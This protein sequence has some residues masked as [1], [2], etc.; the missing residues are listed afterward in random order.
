M[1]KK[2]LIVDDEDVVVDI[3]KRRLTQEGYEVIGA[4]D[5][6]SAMQALRQ[7]PV[8]VIVLDVEM[9]K[10]NGYT[11]IAERRNIPGSENTPV[12]VLTAYDSMEPIF[13]RNGAQAYL[14]KPLQFQ[15]LLAKI[16]EVLGD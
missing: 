3:A 2:I 5:G 15:D 7:G 4:G 13:Q 11:F 10:M 6:E 14:V 9:P 12:I 8:D 16:K 1:V